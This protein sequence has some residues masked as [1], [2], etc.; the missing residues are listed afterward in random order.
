MKTEAKFKPPAKPQGKPAQGKPPQQAK[1]S[2]NKPTG[3][4]PQCEHSPPEGSGAVAAHRIPILDHEGNVRGH[5]GHRAT[6]ATVAR[7]L[8]RHGAELKDQEGRLHWIG[9]KPPPPPPPMMD[10]MQPIEHARGHAEIGLINA[11]RDAL[12][13]KPPK[14]EKSPDKKA[15]KGNVRKS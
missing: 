4:G 9:K 5:V 1:P 7:F 11:R 2:P 6:Q 3:C 12:I 15:A 10:P 14:A 8:G 13:N